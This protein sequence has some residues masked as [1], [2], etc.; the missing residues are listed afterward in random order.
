MPDQIPLSICIPAYKRTDYLKRLLD[1]IH[2]QVFRNFEVIVT[3]DSPDDEVKKLCEQ[4]GELFTIHYHRNSKPLGTPEN[5]NEAI[6]KAN[7]K[8]IKLMHDDDWFTDENS[9]HSFAEA[10]PANPSASFIFCAYRNVDL[11][12]GKTEDFQ[13][14]SFRFKML[15][16]NPAS[17]FSQN[18]IGP[19]SVM[20]HKND[21]RV[22]YDNKLKWL[23]DIDFYIRSLMGRTPVYI[24]QVL[25]NVGLGELQ[26]T[27]DCFRQRPVEIPENFYL[28]NK[29]GLHHL[30][31]IMVYDA[32][33]RLMRNLEIRREADI[34][35]SG[36]TGRIHPALASMI[37]F[38]RLLP[39]AMLSNGTA[40]KSMMF[41]HYLLHYRSIR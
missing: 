11:S 32:W 31:N 12:S 6:R 17:L 8:W 24:N 26:V 33:W 30:K 13:V 16:K 25:V 35:E 1:S 34:V 39:A 20:M 19:P 27:A 2:I 5:W 28:L 15:C 7:G 22:F 18:I 29:A 23:V 4:Y 38:Q 41:L 3:D 37:R 36:Y 10:I 14:D 9:L 40:S 21:R